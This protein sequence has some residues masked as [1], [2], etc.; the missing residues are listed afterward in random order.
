MLNKQAA[1]AVW[2]DAVGTVTELENVADSLRLCDNPDLKALGY[3][4][5][6]FRNH[7]YVMLYRIE[8]NIAYV[9][10]IYHELQDYEN[11]FMD[12]LLD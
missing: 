9:E 1:S 8:E 5:I 3:R 2:N 7:R 10:A 12:S 4:K 11:I 6:N